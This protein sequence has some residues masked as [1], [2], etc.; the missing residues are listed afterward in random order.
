MENREFH[1]LQMHGYGS[2]F[3]LKSMRLALEVYCEGGSHDHD[4]DL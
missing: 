3:V 4:H 2:T 1:L